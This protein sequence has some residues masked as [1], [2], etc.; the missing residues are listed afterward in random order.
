MVLA[1]IFEIAK[2]FGYALLMSLIFVF[3]RAVLPY[4]NT[5][6]ASGIAVFRAEGVPLILV[7]FFTIVLG[8]L[9]TRVNMVMDGGRLHVTLLR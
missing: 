5:N 6:K 9:L 2:T 3:V 8:L 4:I 1:W 7:G